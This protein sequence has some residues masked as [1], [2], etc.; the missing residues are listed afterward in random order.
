MQIHGLN[1]TT[2]LDYPEHV[3]ATVFT[4]GCNFCCPFCHNGDLVLRAKEYPTIL[5]EEVLA[6]LQKRKNIL[7]GV[8]ITGGEPTLQPDLPEFIRKIKAMGYLVKLDTNGYRPEVLRALLEENLLD[9]VAMD[10]KNCKEKYDTTVGVER[11]DI[12]RIEESVILLKEGKIPYEFRTTVVRELHTPED[13]EATGAWIQ[14]ARA[15]FLQSYRDNDNVIQ[16]GYSAY[17]KE[18]LEVFVKVLQKYVKRVE[19]RGVE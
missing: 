6:F 19:L 11:L 5:E 4:G 14:G 12:N 18:E 7:S 1:K 16:K 8:C 9:Y 3:A 13:F 10:I 17:S 15:C 2:L